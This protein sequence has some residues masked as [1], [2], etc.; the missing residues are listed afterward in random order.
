MADTSY[1]TS[2]IEPAMI[3]YVSDKLSVT[4]RKRKV[5]VGKIENNYTIH[6]EVDGMSDDNEIACFASSSNS[7]KIGQIRKLFLDASVL[8]KIPAKK[9]IM[10]FLE[11]GEDLWKTF[12]NSCHGLI[13]LSVIEPMFANIPED[14]KIKLLEI[15]K[16]AKSEVGDLGRV[17]KVPGSRK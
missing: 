7:P 15:R 9:R 14:L 1:I 17:K 10:V 2:V 3:K 5:A 6:F 8:I 16:K 11:D 4:L 12:Y 13:D